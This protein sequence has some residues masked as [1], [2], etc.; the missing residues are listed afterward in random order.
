L[1]QFVRR[2]LVVS[3][4]QCKHCVSRLGKVDSTGSKK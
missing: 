3:E 4:S 2:L 1:Q